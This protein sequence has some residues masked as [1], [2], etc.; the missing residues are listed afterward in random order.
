MISV[1]PCPLTSSVEAPT[2]VRLTT[3]R[4]SARTA[5]TASARPSG[6]LTRTCNS[7]G[8]ASIRRMVP[9]V[10]RRS[11]SASRTSGQSESIRAS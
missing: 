3:G 7:P 6:W 2:P 9:T 1:S 5:A 10:S 11:R 8:G 4:A